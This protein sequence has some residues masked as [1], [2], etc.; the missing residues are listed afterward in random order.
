MIINETLLNMS[1]LYIDALDVKCFNVHIFLAHLWG[2]YAIPLLL[3]VVC[4][5]SSVVYHLCPQ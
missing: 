1:E 3:S 4:R 2:A 5:Q